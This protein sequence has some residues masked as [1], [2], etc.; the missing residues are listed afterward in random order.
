MRIFFGIF[1]VELRR[2]FLKDCF[3]CLFVLSVGKEDGL[4]FFILFFFVFMDREVT[5]EDGGGVMDF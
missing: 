2:S 3:F 5:M 1:L 4:R